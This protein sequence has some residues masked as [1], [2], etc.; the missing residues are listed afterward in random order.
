MSAYIFLTDGFEETEAI[1]TADILCR[2]ELSVFLVSVTK[3][4]EVISSHKISVLADVLFEDIKIVG[5]DILILP[6]GGVLPGYRAHDSLSLVLKTHAENGGLIAAICAAPSYL[7]EIGLLKGKNA[8]CFPTLEHV[9]TENGAYVS[10]D[11][12]VS[13]GNFITSK[14]PATT[15]YFALKIVSTLCGEKTAKEIS[16][17]FLLNTL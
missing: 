5:D 7:A 4:R 11:I 10:R 2:A 3:N 12:V 8:V 15:P 14:G 6:G 1:T 16:E 13:D 17:A 9:L